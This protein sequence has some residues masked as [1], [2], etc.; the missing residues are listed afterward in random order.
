MEKKSSGRGTS[1]V[2]GLSKRIVSSNTFDWI[3]TGVI[4]LQAIALAIEA[5][6]AI[7]SIAKDVELLEAETFSII[8][9]LVIAVF[10]VEAALRLIAVY[11]RP[12]RYFKDPWN[13]FDFAIIILSVIPI[14]G[15]F[16]TI[17]RLVRLLRITRLVTKSNE[18]R[19]I[20]STLV[21]SI[22]SIFNILI[23]LS[24]L[25]FIYAIVGHHL[26][27]N[28]DPEHWSSFPTSL[29]T[30][31]QI[32]TLEGWVNIMEPIVTG[33]GLIYWVYFASFIVIGTFI[34]IN[35]FISVIVRKS[36]EAY[37]QVQR[38]SGIPITQQEVIQE[39]KEIRRILE[40]LEKRIRKETGSETISQSD[41]L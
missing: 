22:P 3:I 30:L 6:P 8:Q 33:L 7:L 26:F 12:Q 19:A 21:R 17:A 16:S 38:E 27:R 24:I 14:S 32:I 40:E 18:L 35:L 9:S 34:I 39:I 4:L 10:I 5:T 25:F 1:R 23:L 15:Q 20:V 31:F 37:K 41:R 36:E 28:A 2:V 11:P 13:C 29:I